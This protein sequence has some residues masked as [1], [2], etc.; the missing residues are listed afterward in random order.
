MLER[1]TKEKNRKRSRADKVWDLNLITKKERKM[2]N[3]ILTKFLLATGV[4]KSPAAGHHCVAIIPIAPSS[5][6]VAKKTRE[7]I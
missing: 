2:N 3:K 1:V 7:L 5:S 6:S 4:C